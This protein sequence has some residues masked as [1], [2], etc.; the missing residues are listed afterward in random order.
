M[1][2][3]INFGLNYGLGAL[4]LKEK[5]KMDIGVDISE[6]ESQNMKATFQAIYPKDIDK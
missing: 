3:S 4:T 6:E 2:K 1:A 5:L